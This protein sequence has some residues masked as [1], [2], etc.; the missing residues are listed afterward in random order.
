M[1]RLPMYVCATVL[2]VT[3]AAMWPASSGHAQSPEGIATP[4]P[5]H[6]DLA[7][8]VAQLQP[9]IAVLR[10]NDLDA[11]SERL[12]GE[13]GALTRIRV[14]QDRLADLYPQDGALVGELATSLDTALDAGNATDA[15]ALTQ[16]LKTTLDG[17][18]PR[19]AEYEQS[20]TYVAAAA[21]TGP[22]DSTITVPVLVGAVPADGFAAYEVTVQFDPMML[23]A[24]EIA[25]TLGQ[26]ASNLDNEAGV[27]SISGFDVQGLIELGPNAPA[28]Q[29]LATVRFSITGPLDT[30][31][32]LIIDQPALFTADGEP[33]P[34]QGVDG[35]V[36]IAQPVEDE[37]S[38]GTV[39][40]YL[41]AGVIVLAGGAG[42]WALRRAAT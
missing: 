8:A 40:R 12:R 35:E 36:T 26:G 33:V 17:L 25:E 32:A 19:L 10:N 4:A 22:P 18:L 5:M 38:G 15:L 29:Q 20:P 11:A 2:A 1:H 16:A 42:L 6:D 9:A 30:A 37:A 24:E 31:T 27:V 23:R 13:A 21:R 28:T 3:L 7:E 41:L 34:A 14:A 39:L